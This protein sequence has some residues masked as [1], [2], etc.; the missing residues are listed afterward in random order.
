MN[1]YEKNS[2]CR[3]LIEVPK[4][5]NSKLCEQ[6][7]QTI[8]FLLPPMFKTCGQIEENAISFCSAFSRVM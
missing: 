5:P 7:N 6:E 3:A 2:G 4:V 1:Q 8:F